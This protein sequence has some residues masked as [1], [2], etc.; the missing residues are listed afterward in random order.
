MIFHSRIS[1]NKVQSFITIAFYERVYYIVVGWV[2]VLLHWLVLGREDA[3]FSRTASIIDEEK[4]TL[5]GRPLRGVSG[6]D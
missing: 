2:A 1:E 3:E 6:F 5:N 4:L